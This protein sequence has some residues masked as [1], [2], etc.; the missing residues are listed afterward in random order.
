MR[1]LFVL[2][3]AVYLLHG[4]AVASDLTPLLLDGKLPVYPSLAKQARI[5]GKVRYRVKIEK[6]LI[7]DAQLL[8]AD[9]PLLVDVTLRNI[10][11][12]RFEESASTTVETEFVYE[13]SK[14]EV[15]RSENPVVELRIP[16]RVRLVTKP[17][18][19]TIN[20]DPAPDI[21]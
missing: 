2:L 12:W 17:V 3:T 5:S 4:V 13:L 10:L 11:T 6:G 8:H 15:P 14:K 16:T 21:R 18:R 20:Y 7:T 9:H 1:R 19:P